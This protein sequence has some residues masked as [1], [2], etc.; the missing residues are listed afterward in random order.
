MRSF[1]FG[2]LTMASAVSALFFLRYWSRTRDRLF[3]FLA[4]AFAAM[5]GEWIYHLSIQRD[6][7]MTAYPVYIIRFA[8]FMIILIGILDKN[9]RGNR[10]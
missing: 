2:L 9:R 6:L 3:G 7:E 4:L 10:S 8:A 5:V 1:I